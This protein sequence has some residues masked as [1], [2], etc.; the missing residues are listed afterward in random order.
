MLQKDVVPTAYFQ[1]EQSV[2]DGYNPTIDNALLLPDEDQLMTF[3]V[4]NDVTYTDENETI[5]WIYGDLPLVI[6]VPHGGY[7]LSQSQEGKKPFQVPTRASGCHEQK[8]FGG[9]PHLILCRLH[10]SQVDMNRGEMDASDTSEENDRSVGLFLDLHGQSHDPRHQIGYIIRGVIY[11]EKTDD[12]IDVDD[13]LTNTCSIRGSLNNK[14]L[15][16]AL[17]GQKSLGSLL[18]DNGYSSVPSPAHPSP[19]TVP[20]FNGGYCTATYGSS[21]TNKQERS[22]MSSIQIESSYLGVR[23][24]EDNRRKFAESLAVVM[25]SWMIEYI[26][27]K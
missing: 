10:R 16:A 17:R 6:A 11:N 27:S 4:T 22:R 13:H 2:A 23:D 14:T 20:Y 26:H 24:S 1:L 21:T 19:G 3:S 8:E 12:E 7:L 25:K 18:E 15:S 5:E 9:T